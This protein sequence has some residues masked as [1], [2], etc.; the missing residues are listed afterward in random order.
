MASGFNNQH[1]ANIE[2]NNNIKQMSQ[3]SA[4]KINCKNFT[5]H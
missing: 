5:F 3:Q 2:K 4:F 1:I